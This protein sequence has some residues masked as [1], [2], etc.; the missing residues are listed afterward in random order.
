MSFGQISWEAYDVQNP[1][2]RVGK[3][4]CPLGE[5]AASSHDVDCNGDAVSKVQKDDRGGYNGIEGAIQ[6][7]C[8][9]GYGR[10][11]QLLPG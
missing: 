11:C 8:L 7:Q 10:C 2:K 9:C 1:A 4:K 5:C 3:D 6:G